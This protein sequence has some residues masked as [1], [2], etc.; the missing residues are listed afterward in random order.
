MQAPIPR[1]IFNISPKILD[2]VVIPS[3]IHLYATCQ[4]DLI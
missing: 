2:I 4:Q 1:E 3:T